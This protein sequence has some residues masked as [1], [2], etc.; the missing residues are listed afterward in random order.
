MAEKEHDWTMDEREQKGENEV[1]K[2]AAK[3]NYN[4]VEDVIS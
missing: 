3:E 1:G 4:L 2:N